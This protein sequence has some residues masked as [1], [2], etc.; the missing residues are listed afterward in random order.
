VVCRWIADY[1][2]GPGK[3]PVHN[4]I[5]ANMT[6]EDGRIVRHLDHFDFRTW[7]RQALGMAAGWPGLHRIVQRLLGLGARKGLRDFQRRRLARG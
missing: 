7:A 4:V 6:V 1:P 2:F 3:R 5:V